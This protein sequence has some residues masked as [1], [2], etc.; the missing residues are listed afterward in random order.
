MED[1]TYQGM[2][3]EPYIKREDI[4]R[5]VERLLGFWHPYAI[6]KGA[7]L[8]PCYLCMR[9]TLSRNQPPVAHISAWRLPAFSASRAT[10]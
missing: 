9:R 6:K 4:A 7:G 1:V 2:T 10:D 5:Q 8:C 3:F